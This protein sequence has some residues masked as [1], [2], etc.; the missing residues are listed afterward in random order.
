MQPSSHQ[1]IL[2]L[3]EEMNAVTY[4]ARLVLQSVSDIT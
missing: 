4:F 3:L 1:S 2:S